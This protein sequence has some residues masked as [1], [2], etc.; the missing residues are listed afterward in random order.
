VTEP[1]TITI[2]RIPWTPASA[3]RPLP[4]G[5]HVNHDSRSRL[6]PY[7][8]R[9]QVILAT[10][11][12]TRRIGILDQGNL[13]SCFPPGTRV[14]MADGSE[15]AIEDVRLLE[16][17]VTAEGRTGRIVC[18]FARDEDGGLLRLVL[19][20]HSH[21]RM[22]REHPVLT[23]RGY[24]AAQEL[25]VGDEV[26]LP[27]YTALEPRTH[28]VTAEHVT[29]PS[30]RLTRGNR[31]YGIPGRRGLSVGSHVLPD[32]FELDAAFGRLIGLFLA[33]GSCDS[34]KAV[35]TFSLLERDTLVAETVRLLE[36]YGVTAHV[37][38]LPAHHSTKVTVHGTA[39][40]RLL[41]SLCGDGAGKKRLHPELA[42]GSPQFLEA[43]LSGWLAGDGHTRPD[44]TVEG[45]TI[46]RSLA[47]EMYDIAQAL[48]KHPVLVRA[49]PTMN[50]HAAS[51]QPRWTLTMAPGPGRCRQD[52]THVWRKVRQIV[53]EDYVG[54]VYD[55]EVAGDH[56]YVAEGV[57][58]H[59]CTGNAIVGA[60]GSD[61][62]WADLP[63][64]HPVMDEAEAVRLYSAAEKLDGGTGYPPED[65]G[66]SGLSVCKAAKAAGLIAGY[67]NGFSLTD[68]LAAL[69]AGPVITGVDWFDSFDSPGS[70]GLISIS[71]GAQ[72]RGGHE[73]TVR[74]CDVGA[75]T[76]YCDNSWGTTY[77]LK[78]SFLMSWDTWDQLL[79]RQGDVTIPVPLSQPAPV[80]VP[81]TPVP[82]E[83]V[84]VPVADGTD[85]AFAS[86]ATLAWARATHTAANK[87]AA[88]AFRVWAQAKGLWVG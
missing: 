56:S 73:F 49:E 77:G 44:R 65:E 22:T 41:S 43:V 39:W 12:H 1:Y 14:R 3:A 59:N 60:L 53:L 24:V 36:R 55:L 33:E 19:W 66:S 45:I 35:W 10:I 70:D 52:A 6:Y 72:V 88:R 7:Q 69:Q 11:L 47:L 51:R 42:A 67:A 5:R 84:P 62:D 58:V 16:R 32:K 8:P 26:A 71:K 4:L 28:I 9:R 40:N 48:G 81:P 50:R 46:S 68:A 30:H 87:K 86:P 76:V 85:R 13:G 27:R 21:L 17:V 82:P 61:P 31:W 20:G 80:P 2:R 83:P 38:E 34:G 64:K 57:G 63:A 75:R 23:A 79:A 25:R 78:G 54:P 74:G 15:R 18:M 37:R 29:R